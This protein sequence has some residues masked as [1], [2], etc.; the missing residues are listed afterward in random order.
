MPPIARHT[1]FGA[2]F[3]VILENKKLYHQHR[4]G[5]QDRTVRANSLYC[6][7]CEVHRHYSEH[8]SATAIKEIQDL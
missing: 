3:S 2:V 4:Q 8:N 1:R 7:R 6:K 5:K